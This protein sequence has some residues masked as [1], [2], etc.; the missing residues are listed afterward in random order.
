LCRRQFD[1]GKVA[2]T[3]FGYH[4]GVQSS[5]IEIAESIFHEARW[6][7]RFIMTTALS[8]SSLPSI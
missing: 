5:H 6:V 3:T 7:S 4:S 2:R 8:A 1:S